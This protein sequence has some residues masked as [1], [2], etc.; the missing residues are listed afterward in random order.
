M[1]FQLIFGKSEARVEFYMSRAQAEANRFVFDRLHAQKDQIE[2]DFGAALTWQPLPDRKACRIVY[3]KPFDGYDKTN[4]RE[5]IQWL[6]DHMIRFE[7]AL[8]GP[9]ERI[10]HD[11]KQADLT[12]SAEES[13][14]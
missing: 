7:K 11:L 12:P 6:V 10:K 13:L 9:L 4:W 14:N 1:M 3:S 5:M 8:S 2:A